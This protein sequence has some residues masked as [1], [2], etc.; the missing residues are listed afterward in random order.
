MLKSGIKSGT[1]RGIGAAIVAMAAF[2]GAAP[3]QTPSIP[4]LDGLASGEWELS[5]RDSDRKDRI[6]LGD[7]KQF[8]QVMHRR[9]SCSHYIIEQSPNSARVSYKCSARG[10]GVTSLRRETNRLVRLDTQ[11]VSNGD[12]FSEQIEARRVGTCG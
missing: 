7:P 1:L 8:L 9:N 10:H 4:A 12:W 11:G 6:C 2:A 5:F 3:A